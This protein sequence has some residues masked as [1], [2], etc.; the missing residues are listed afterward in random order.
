MFGGLR[1]ALFGSR[2]GNVV[3]AINDGDTEAVRTYLS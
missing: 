1:D 2:V 3:S